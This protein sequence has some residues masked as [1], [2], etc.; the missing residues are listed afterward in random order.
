MVC[1]DVDFAFHWDNSS[2]HGILVLTRHKQMG[3]V[4]T[5]HY[6]SA[7]SKRGCKSVLAADVFA[8]IDGLDVRYKVAYSLS[9][10][11][12]IELELTIYTDS[13]SI[14]GLRISLAHTTYLR[15]HI[16]LSVVR[17][18]MDGVTTVS[19]YGSKGIEIQQTVSP[20]LSDGSKL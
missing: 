7:K 12:G 20:R 16:D 4:N 17:E 19:L 9:E 14:Y 8:F 13:R 10:I 2:Q 3:L 1:I 15:L 6:T 18:V 5:I 11:L